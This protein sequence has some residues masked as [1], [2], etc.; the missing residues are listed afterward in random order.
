[1]PGW[2]RPSWWRFAGTGCILGASVVAAPA[3]ATGPDAILRG[4]TLSETRDGA[5]VWEARA[6]RSEV[7]DADQVV[8][9]AR[10]ADAV[11]V[12]IHSREG[13]LTV[14]AQAAA[15]NL[16]TRDIEF[17]GPVAA[18]SERGVRLETD[19]LRWSAA[20]HV[21][22][23]DRPVVIER[24]GLR[25]HGAGLEAAPDLEALTLSGAVR[26]EIIGAAPP[27]ARAGPGAAPN[28]RGAELGARKATGRSAAAKGRAKARRAAGD[29]GPRRAAR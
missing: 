5:V 27:A 22:T 23:S 7:F 10:G 9:L 2:L 11:R 24:A 19:V 29:R 8:R 16:R 25:L 12:V 14:E 13:L 1:M 15:I 20:R 6:A 4:V 3:G 17:T 18:R 21:L 28:G 26:S